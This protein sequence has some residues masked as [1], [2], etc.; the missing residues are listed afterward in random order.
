FE[1]RPELYRVP[2]SIRFTHIYFSPDRRG[3]TVKAD[4][5]RALNQLAAPEQPPRWAS[6][7]GDPFMLQYAHSLQSPQEV[8]HVFGQ[9]FADALFE[10]TPGAWQGPVESSYGHHLIQV[11]EK[12]EGQL[13]D[14]SLVHDQVLQNLL[15]ERREKAQV[16]AYEVLRN[17]YE[18]SITDD[19]ALAGIEILSEMGGG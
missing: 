10:L 13:P 5:E 12:V 19:V 4:A 1:R 6:E 11:S 15:R 16:Q 7:L 18:I 17:R 8:S 9:S 14:M 2:P 3:E